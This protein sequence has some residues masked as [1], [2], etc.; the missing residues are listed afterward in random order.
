VATLSAVALLFTRQ[1]HSPAARAI[2]DL[3][4]LLEND[5]R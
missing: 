2:R 3:R 5:P 4:R 1:R